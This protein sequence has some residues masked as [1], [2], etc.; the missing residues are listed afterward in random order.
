MPYLHLR[1]RVFKASIFYKHLMPSA[2]LQ[3]MILPLADDEQQQKNLLK[4]QFMPFLY[5][6]I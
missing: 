2:S 5:L 6:I 1:H 3:V 4:M